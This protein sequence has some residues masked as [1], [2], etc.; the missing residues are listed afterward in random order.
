MALLR[1]MN[2]IF[3]NKK[4]NYIYSIIYLIKNQ[5]EY[6]LKHFE[7]YIFRK[8]PKYVSKVF[9]TKELKENS[10]CFFYKII[11]K[12]LGTSNFKI[13]FIS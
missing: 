1:T 7:N 3:K 5:I 12:W 11:K 10:Q 9:I 13:L 2:L 4:L 8:T 6:H